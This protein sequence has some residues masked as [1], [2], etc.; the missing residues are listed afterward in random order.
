MTENVKKLADALT[1]KDK[2]ESYL[3]NLEKLK[4]EGSVTE[5]QYA[6]ISKEYY[7]RLGQA[8]SQVVLIKNELKKEHESIQ[9]KISAQKQQMAVIEA[10]H[11]VGELS[12]EQFKAAEKLIEDLSVHPALFGKKDEP[13]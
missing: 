9:Q 12:A 10:K 6:S 11:K 7:E 3:S 1:A 4:V 2:V 8:T 5:E 13:S